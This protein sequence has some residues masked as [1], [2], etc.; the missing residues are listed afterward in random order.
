MGTLY[1]M[2]AEISELYEALQMADLED[3]LRDTII[4]NHIEGMGAVDKVEGYCQIISQLEFDSD[5][6][7]EEIKRLQARRKTAENS[8]IRLKNALI[9]F[10]ESSGN[11]KFK[12]GTFSVSVRQSKS[13][14][15]TNIQLIPMEYLTLEPKV[16]KR[17]IG[18]ALRGG[19]EVPGAEYEFKK[20]VVIR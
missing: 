2:T 18:E 15:V 14:N 3:E 17:K 20:G 10:L 8:I 7:S 19:A 4:E 13:V 11:E 16:D 12:A 5:M 1:E 9:G 6:Y